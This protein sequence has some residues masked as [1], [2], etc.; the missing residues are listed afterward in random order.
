MEAYI[1]QP[2]RPP[3]I[4]A[5][6]AMLDAQKQMVGDAGLELARALNTGKISS[7]QFV[8]QDRHRL[9]AT[10]H[11]QAMADMAA[12]V[13]QSLIKLQT[14]FENARWA[15]GTGRLLPTPA[16]GRTYETGAAPGFASGGM[17][18]R[19]PGTE[20]SDS[21]PAWLSHNEFVQP[22]AA[23]RHYGVAFMEAIRNRRFADGGHVSLSDAEPNEPA[24]TAKSVAAAFEA[25]TDV[26]IN[27][28]DRI[29]YQRILE[30]ASR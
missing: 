16:G 6:R 9:Q 12:G 10:R 24:A 21:I 22:A 19:G 3:K 14:D 1:A 27:R 23:V 8:D 13:E 2:A 7:Q 29:H 28:D 15:L 4:P 20:T 26:L 11:L 30:Q 25:V 18:I 5:E 17:H